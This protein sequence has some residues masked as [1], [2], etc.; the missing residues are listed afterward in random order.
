MPSLDQAETKALDPNEGLGT[1]AQ[2]HNLG[3]LEAM[4]Y[5]MARIGAARRCAAA[6]GDAAPE[7]LPLLPGLPLALLDPFPL[8]R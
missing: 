5:F 6:E 3:K 8:F 4:P 2:H 1:I 7:A